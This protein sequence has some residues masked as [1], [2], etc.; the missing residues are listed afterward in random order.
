MR[1]EVSN[2]TERLEIS[3]TIQTITRFTTTFG[4][5]PSARGK[6]NQKCSR[7]FFGLHVYLVTGS[8]RSAMV[9]CATIDHFSLAR[10]NFVS[11]AIVTLSL[12]LGPLSDIAVETPQPAWLC[13]G[14]MQ[15]V[16]KDH[17]KMVSVPS[18]KKVGCP[19]AN[20]T[21]LVTLQADLC[22]VCILHLQME[23]TTGRFT[24]NRGGS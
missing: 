10:P 4:N 20:A 19:S 8:T 12:Y 21:D 3:S 23:C 5:Y 15:S 2:D 17:R 9:R 14:K 22:S 11:D 1:D 13:S 7:R 16:A 24:E 18:S 6:E